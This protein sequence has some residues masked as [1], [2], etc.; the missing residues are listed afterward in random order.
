MFVFL[1]MW[2]I[3]INKSSPEAPLTRSIC[4]KSKINC[5]KKMQKQIKM[6][7]WLQILTE[8]RAPPKI[9]VSSP[10][11][12]KQQNQQVKAGG[13]VA[14]TPVPLNGAPA[15]SSPGLPGVPPDGT[16]KAASPQPRRNSFLASETSKHST[17]NMRRYDSHSLLSENSI[18]SSRFD[19]TDG[20]S[21]PQW[22]ETISSFW[23][24]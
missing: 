13:N 12:V 20:A 9:T 16:D 10:S 1:S 3:K 11:A 21:F 15:A 19:L 18:A 24:L 14:A 22:V 4:D 7:N 6:F 8:E 23:N 2:V 17:L 5:Y